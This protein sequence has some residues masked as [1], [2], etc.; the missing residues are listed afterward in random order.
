MSGVFI[1]LSTVLAVVVSSVALRGRPSPSSPKPSFQPGNAA[2]SIW[3]VIFSYGIVYSASV[4]LKVLPHDPFDE[5]TY[6]SAFV[7]SSVWAVL[8]RSQWYVSSTACLCLAALSA[9]LNAFRHPVSPSLRFLLR[10]CASGLLAGWLWV[11][12]LLQV[13]IF[14]LS[15]LPDA[16]FTFL[17]DTPRT[18]GVA[19]VL[20]ALA[21]VLTRTCVPML[22]LLWASYNLG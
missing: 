18:L 20:M 5:W 10:D 15:R 9:S 19:S 22:P 7:L 1:G 14:L 3:G 12:A 16:S 2:F 4:Y 8:F 6:A 17:F 13:G 21:C 11:A